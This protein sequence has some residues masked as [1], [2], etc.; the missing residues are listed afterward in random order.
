MIWYA[1]GLIGV[2]II[3]YFDSKNGNLDGTFLGYFAGGFLG[4]VSFSFAL[5]VLKEEFR[6]KRENK[7]Y[8]MLGVIDSVLM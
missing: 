1:L 4:F 8:R 7:R 5:W 3:I 2:G 6:Y